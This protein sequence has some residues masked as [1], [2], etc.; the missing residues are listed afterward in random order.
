MNIVSLPAS[1]R[2]SHDQPTSDHEKPIHL[3]M[4]STMRIATLIPIDVVS[5]AVQALH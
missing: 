2:T 3:C 1:S 5:I 4:P